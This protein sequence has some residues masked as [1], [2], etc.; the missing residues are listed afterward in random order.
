MFAGSGDHQYTNVNGWSYVNNYNL[1]ERVLRFIVDP[2]GLRITYYSTAGTSNIRERNIDNV[3]P[4]FS[5]LTATGHV[6]AM[7][8]NSLSWGVNGNKLYAVN[9]NDMV[10]LNISAPYNM[11]NNPSSNTRT[12][13][14]VTP[15]Y[16]ATKCW[17]D[18]SEQYMYIVRGTAGGRIYRY[19]FT[20]INDVSTLALTNDQISPNPTADGNG[21]NW[22]LTMTEDR[23][24][25]LWFQGESAVNN[26]RIK[27]GV[28]NS[29]YS[30]TTMTI[31]Q[32]P[33]LY[34]NLGTTS[35]DDAYFDLENGYLYVNTFSPTNKMHVFRYNGD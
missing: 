2:Q 31:T 7:G 12:G 23:L 15:N 5:S 35:V 22:A 9:G 29:K 10:Q 27:L 8:T 20:S 16:T 32:S 4:N 21:F 13:F 33:N 24:R 28:L 11:Q 6:E 25:M 34:S 18:T 19:P 17:G 30:I 26:F 1:P 14:N 3:A